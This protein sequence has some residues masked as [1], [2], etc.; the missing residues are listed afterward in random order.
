MSP[1]SAHADRGLAGFS[2]GAIPA[3]ASQRVSRSNDIRTFDRGKRSSL[4]GQQ[5][6]R[7]DRAARSALTT[8]RIHS[9]SSSSQAG[10]SN[11]RRDLHDCRST[12]T[13]THRPQST[14]SPRSP[15]RRARR[16]EDKDESQ[17]CRHRKEKITQFT[18]TIALYS[19]SGIRQSQNTLPGSSHSSLRCPSP[20]VQ[21]IRPRRIGLTV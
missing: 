1:G 13:P 6:P 21:T 10:R 9:N 4:P 19:K 18:T 7:N 14:A 16:A 20:R 5:K 12:R 17:S 3:A 11:R 8:Q 15:R 2:R